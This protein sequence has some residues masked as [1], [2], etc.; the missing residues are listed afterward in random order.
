M[1]DSY[2][3]DEVEK[4][5]T[6]WLKT[7]LSLGHVEHPG[8]LSPLSFT[9]T[10]RHSITKEV[11]S[12]YLVASINIVNRQNMLIGKLREQAHVLKTDVIKCQGSVIK[13][14]EDLIAAK[15]Q[16][17][18]ALQTVI[19]A[20]VQDTV[21]TEFKSYSEAAKA[22]QPQTVSNTGPSTAFSEDTLKTL[23]KHV[24]AEEDRSRNLMIFG[25]RES[26]DEHLGDKVSEVF[27]HLGEKP[28]VEASRLGKKGSSTTARPVKVTLSSSTIVH[29]ILVNARNLRQSEKHKSVFL[30]PDR[31]ME[32][33]AL[34]KQLVLDLKKKK[35]E[36]PK[37]RHYIKGTQ[38][39]SVDVPVN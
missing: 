38:L 6:D 36:Q 9:G 4:D 1:T 39:Y 17:L 3:L 10:G 35:E 2:K 28:K 34:R 8:A 15:D 22:T 20:S 23:L 33:Q 11:L 5:G 27:E 24:V 12:K 14:Q 31:S 19:V 16:Q 29:Q 32:Q 37:R 7:A 13:L 30:T 21:K 26:D 18:D 25:L